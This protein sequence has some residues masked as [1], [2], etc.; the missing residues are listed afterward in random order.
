MN[1]RI[2]LQA[3]WPEVFSSQVKLQPASQTD[4]H[5]PHQFNMPSTAESACLLCLI[6]LLGSATISISRAELLPEEQ[7]TSRIWM[8]RQRC[9]RRTLHMPVATLTQCRAHPDCFMCHDYCR[10][11]VV[12]ERNLAT[13][14]CADR[15]FCSRGCRTACGFHQL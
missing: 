5:S 13:A 4:R 8:C 9:Y 1:A 10:V 2:K 3:N 12:A 11:L 7:T 15:S 6:C 14:M